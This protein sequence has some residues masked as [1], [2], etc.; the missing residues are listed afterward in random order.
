[1]K[2]CTDCHFLTKC[3]SDGKSGVFTFNWDDDEIAT[4]TVQTDRCT[5]ECHRKVWSLRLDGGLDYKAEVQKDRKKCVFFIPR[6]RGMSLPTAI[7]MLEI[8][9]TR[10]TNKIAVLGIIVVALIGI[11]GWFL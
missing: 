6:Q 11:V 10:R 3:F 1:M 8:G 7:E 9:K 5:P 4:K 2:T